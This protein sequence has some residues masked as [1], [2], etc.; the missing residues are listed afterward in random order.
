MGWAGL[1]C[2]AAEPVHVA[3]HLLGF[4]RTLQACD[5]EMYLAS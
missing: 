5:K 3:A 2:W 4:L 1:G